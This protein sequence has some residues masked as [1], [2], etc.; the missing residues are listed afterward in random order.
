MEAIDI[1]SEGCRQLSL[2]ISQEQLQQFFK[3]K[4]ILLHWNKKM[5]LTAIEDEREIV[6][7]HFLDSVSCFLIK[8]LDAKSKVIDVGTGA[9]FPGIPIKIIEPRVTLTLLDSL[10][11]RIQF[12]QEVCGSLSLTDVE[13]VHGRAEDIGQDK[14]Y[15]EQYDIAVARAVAPLN[16]LAEYCLPFVKVGGFFICQKGPQLELEMKEAAKAINVLGG[17]VVQQ[18][19]VHLPYSDIVHRIVVVEKVKHTPTNYPRKAGKPS[20]E[21]IS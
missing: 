11:K 4:D 18:E 1:L 16:V 21:P 3:Y 9:G 2:N 20:K 8:G 15:R 10:N 19:I 17:K 7:K 6:I 13:F 12:L 5:N 14:K